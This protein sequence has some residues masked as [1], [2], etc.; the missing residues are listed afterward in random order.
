VSPGLEKPAKP[1]N[2]VEK[3]YEYEEIH[4]AMYQDPAFPIPDD[5]ELGVPLDDGGVHGALGWKTVTKLYNYIT[6]LSRLDWGLSSSQM[7]FREKRTCVTQ[8]ALQDTYH[9]ARVIDE[10]WSTPP[11]RTEAMKDIIKGYEGYH[12]HTGTVASEGYGEMTMNANAKMLYVL[13]N[14]RALLLDKLKPVGEGALDK[15]WD[16]GPHSTFMDIG[17][18][19]GKVNFHAKVMCDVRYS[20]GIECVYSR[21][22]IAENILRNVQVSPLPPL[23]SLSLTLRE[24]PPEYPGRPHGRCTGVQKT[25]RKEPRR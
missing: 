21:Y 10:Y 14:M 3:A 19:Y 9:G 8:N 17:S 20:L 18:G 25:P 24:H 4:D 7:A 11:A 1:V 2:R 12:D 22:Q 23:N 5:R 16:L 15:A 13:A 6:K